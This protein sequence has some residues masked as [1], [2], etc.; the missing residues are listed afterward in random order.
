MRVGGQRHALDILPPGK[1]QYSLCR[2]LGGPQGRSGRVRKISPPTGFDPPTVQ[3]IAILY[4]TKKFAF[5]SVC[6]NFF[7]WELF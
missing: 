5:I 4:S 6:L 3:P 2:R 7:V 1:T